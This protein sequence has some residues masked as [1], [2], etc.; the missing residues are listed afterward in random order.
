MKA[1]E[2]EKILG[3]RILFQSKKYG[4]NIDEAV[5][6]EVSPSGNY[7][8]LM[9]SHGNKFWKPTQEINPIEILKQI[10]KEKL[11]K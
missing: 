7:T 6:L 10:K 4:Y 8:R 11:K 3:K 9:N 2:A 1:E 5:V